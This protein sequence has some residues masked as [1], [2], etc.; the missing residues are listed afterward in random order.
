VDETGESVVGAGLL[1]VGGA[2]VAVACAGGSAGVPPPG[3]QAATPTALAAAPA[4]A[5]NCRREDSRAG[6]V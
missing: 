6:G 2:A 1:T 5:R 3:A 4:I